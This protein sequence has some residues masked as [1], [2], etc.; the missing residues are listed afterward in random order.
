MDENEYLEKDR[1]RSTYDAI[2]FLRKVILF[3]L[4]IKIKNQDIID[5]TRRLHTFKI[6]MELLIKEVKGLIKAI[7]KYKFYLFDFYADRN[8]K[9]L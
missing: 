9:I 3:Y 7:N 6:S 2:K 8:Y 5:K 4:R 1:I